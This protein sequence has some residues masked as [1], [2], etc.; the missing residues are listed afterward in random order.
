MPS[1]RE[2]EGP[3]GLGKFTFSRSTNVVKP[4]RTTVAADVGA[5]ECPP[6]TK[7][8]LWA[9][10]ERRM[11]FRL[12]DVDG[13]VRVRYGVNDDPAKWGFDRLGLDFD[14]EVARGFPIIEARVDYPADG[15]AGS[16]GWV[17]AVRYWVNGQSEPKLVAPD[18]APQLKG[19]GVPYFSF[20]LEPTLFDAPATTDRDMVWRAAAFLTQTPDLLMSRTVGAVCGFTWGYDVHDGVP[21]PSELAAAQANDWAA[22]V[23]DLRRALLDWE[24][25][26][27]DRLP[28]FDD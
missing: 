27:V 2:P 15:Y 21:T 20:G 22:A 5:S 8:G 28:P 25:L 10:T 6:E 18:V 24:F 12:R 26:D 7:R 9:V 13:V 11:S 4:A 23:A 16:V 19:A 14:V 17:Q 1:P 3:Q